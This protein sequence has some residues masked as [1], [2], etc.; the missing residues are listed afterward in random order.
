MVVTWPRTLPP[1]IIDKYASYY[2][3]RGVQ[4]LPTVG[5]RD[6]KKH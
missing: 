2:G 6:K 5:K 1:D 4:A 3:I